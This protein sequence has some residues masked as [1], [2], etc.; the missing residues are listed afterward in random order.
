[1]IRPDKI[2]LRLLSALLAAVTLAACQPAQSAATLTATSTQPMVASLTPTAVAASATA[3]ALPTIT[4]QPTLAPTSGPTSMPGMI[5]QSAPEEVWYHDETIIIY[6]RNG[7]MCALKPGGDTAVYLAPS[8]GPPEWS[9]GVIRSSDG[10]MIAFLRRLQGD[11]L[12][13]LDEIW[14]VGVDGTGLK[15]I[16]S[17]DDLPSLDAVAPR[18]TGR[19]TVVDYAWIPG[20]HKIA[21][22]TGDLD[23][24]YVPYNDLNVIDADTGVVSTLVWPGA[25]GQYVYAAP[26]GHTL[27]FIRYGNTIKDTDN[28][29]RPNWLG[30]IDADG[31]N[32]QRN[33]F[34]FMSTFSNTD[35][36]R[37]VIKPVWR[38]GS[39][40]LWVA[41]SQ[42]HPLLTEMTEIDGWYIPRDGSA[43]GRVFH[44]E[45]LQY[46]I[47]NP[48]PVISPDGTTLAFVGTY[49]GQSGVHLFETSDM[50]HT[51]YSKDFSN[52][53]EWESDSRH[54]EF[55]AYLGSGTEA[56]LLRGVIGGPPVQIP[57]PAGPTDVPALDCVPK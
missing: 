18:G 50:S 21:F 44:L 1:M 30:F 6:T 49:Q 13:V 40:G 25:G 26:D 41:L 29:A 22:T 43:A 4:P 47:W 57:G 19:R 9:P 54:F 33:V 11:Y 24:G 37:L 32:L 7:Q 15:R 56:S 42:E 48:R 27:A 10:K 38:T 28:V 5:P 55:D 39:T 36:Y 23:Y 51:L 16:L 3:T 20:T 52:D 8:D 34:S 45:G 14:T 53:L 35:Q 17:L 31:T 12:V 46:S 2:S